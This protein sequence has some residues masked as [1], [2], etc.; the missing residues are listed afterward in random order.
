MSDCA[1]ATLDVAAEHGPRVREILAR[2]DRDN[3]DYSH[4]DPTTTQF[5]WEEA[6]WGLNYLAEP[7]WT[8][9]EEEPPAVLAVLREEGIPYQAT[10][11][12][13]Y[14]WSPH[15][16]RWSPEMEEHAERTTDLDGTPIMEAYTYAAARDVLNDRAL[17]EWI[18]AYY[19]DDPTRWKVPQVPSPTPQEL[20]EALA[21][22]LTARA[23]EVR[24]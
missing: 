8:M 24:T 3:Y 16:V 19:G 2:L 6:P 1:Q 23:E 14:T 21:A 12:G 18:D 10:D 17:L 11:G 9:A 22:R 5:V 20:W 4:E 7:G 13:H 15:E